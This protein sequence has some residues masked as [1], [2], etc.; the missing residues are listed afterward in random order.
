MN[1]QEIYENIQ[2]GDYVIFKHKDIPFKM[3]CKIIDF[4]H[5]PGDYPRVY[6]YNTL[7][8]NVECNMYIKN[9]EYYK[10]IDEVQYLLS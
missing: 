1:E 6:F 7:Y 8:P 3:T 5:H 4:Y 2:I 10:L 9:I